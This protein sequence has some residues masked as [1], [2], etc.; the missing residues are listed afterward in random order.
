VRRAPRPERRGQSTTTET[1]EGY[2]H[3]DSGD[4]HFQLPQWMQQFAA[5]FPLKWLTQGMR[6]VLLPEGAE[7]LEV[8]GSFEMPRVAM[9][10]PVWTVL[11]AMLAWG[12]F[13][14]RRRGDGCCVR[15]THRSRGR[16][17]R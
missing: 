9:V 4:V 16:I 15:R 1:L 10:L 12:F 7:A 2:R 14:W 5:L 3:R 13:R 8:V 11:R 6:Y 17:V